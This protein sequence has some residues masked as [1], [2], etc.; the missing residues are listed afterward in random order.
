[1]SPDQY[2]QSTNT[3]HKIDIINDSITAYTYTETEGNSMFCGPETVERPQN[4]LLSRGLC[5]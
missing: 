2:L 5:Q 3:Y 1:M 4:I